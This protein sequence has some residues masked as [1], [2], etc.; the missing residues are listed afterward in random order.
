MVPEPHIHLWDDA[1]QR[2]HT[3]VFVLKR[4]QMSTQAMGRLKCEKYC[5][6]KSGKGSEIVLFLF[7]L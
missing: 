4:V 1:L 5:L 6:Q 7:Q 3:L 2:L